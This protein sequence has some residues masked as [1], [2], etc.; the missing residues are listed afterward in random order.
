MSEYERIAIY[1]NDTKEYERDE[2]LMFREEIER[3]EFPP[4]CLPCYKSGIRYC[5][6]WLHGYFCDE[7]LEGKPLDIFK[8][9][10]RRQQK[11]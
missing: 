5:D 2:V 9:F 1:R 4:K 6:Y 11:K 3:G 10:I 8:G 7:I